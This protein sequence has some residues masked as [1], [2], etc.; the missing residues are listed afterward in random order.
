MRMFQDP[1]AV[2]LHREPI[3]FRVGI[4]GLAMRVEQTLGLS[5]LTG[6]LFIPF[7][8]QAIVAIEEA[9]SPTPFTAACAHRQGLPINAVAAALMQSPLTKAHAQALARGTPVT[10]TQPAGGS[11]TTGGGSSSSGPSCHGS[12]GA[13]GLRGA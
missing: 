3:D 7:V 2:Y 12:P 4:D 1:Q 9:W 11:G 8:A 10:G 5:P 6:A 13:Y